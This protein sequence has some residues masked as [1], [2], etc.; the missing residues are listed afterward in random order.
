VV[1]CCENIERTSYDTR[2]YLTI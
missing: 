1:L 2:Q